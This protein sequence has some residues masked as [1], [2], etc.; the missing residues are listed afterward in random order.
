MF[1][2]KFTTCNFV[3]AKKCDMG[4]ELRNRVY[5]FECTC[6]HNGCRHEHN[7]MKIKFMNISILKMTIPNQIILNFWNSIMTKK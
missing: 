4:I 1:A 7:L 5:G 3:D 6:Y 2:I